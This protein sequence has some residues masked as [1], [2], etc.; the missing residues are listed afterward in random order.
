MSDP[1]PQHYQPAAVRNA[2]LGLHTG[3]GRE[4]DRVT[5]ICYGP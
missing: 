3:T 4:T 1:E 5:L 2:E